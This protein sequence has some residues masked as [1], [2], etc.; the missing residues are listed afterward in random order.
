MI[1]DPREKI[2]FSG[3]GPGS[4]SDG[5]W[6]TDQE[7]QDGGAQGNRTEH[8]QDDSG[9]PACRVRLLIR[10][11]RPQPVECALGLSGQL[12]NVG[13]VLGLFGVHAF[14]QHGHLPPR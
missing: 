5:V 1:R 4:G 11:V 2:L 12:R 13:L 3:I 14:L 6:Q 8:G 7:T 10:H 9:F